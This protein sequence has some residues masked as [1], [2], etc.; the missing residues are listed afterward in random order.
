MTRA[1]LSVSLPAETW[2]LDTRCTHPETSIT[3]LAA[4]PTDETGSAL[5]RVTGDA[6]GVKE[7]MDAAEGITS[8]SVLRETDGEALI[9]F[10]TT[11]PMVLLAASEAGLPIELPVRIRDGEATLDVTAPHDRLSALGEQ[12]EGFGMDYAVEHVYDSFD[13]ESLLTDR[14]RGVLQTAVEQG[15]YDTPR[16]CTLAELATELDVAKST[17]S[18]VLHRA[19]GTVLKRVV[20]SPTDPAAIGDDPM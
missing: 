18:E 10:D 1:R 16:R 5:I 4:M 9:G 7:A 2:V 17:L 3:V 20:T 14:Q 12:L 19:E 15:Y 11:E 8:L 13:P 6:T